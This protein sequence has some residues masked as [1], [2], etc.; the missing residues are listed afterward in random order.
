MRAIARLL[1]LHAA[2]DLRVKPVKSITIAPGHQCLYVSSGRAPPIQFASMI[3][4]E[5]YVYM[6]YYIIYTHIYTHNYYIYTHI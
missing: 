5:K 3:Y 2:I 6:L 4:V 1:V